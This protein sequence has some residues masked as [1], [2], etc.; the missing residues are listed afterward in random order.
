MN[1]WYS[2]KNIDE[3]DSP[4][5]VIYPERVKQNITLA[6]QMIGDAN[7]LRPHV[8]TNKIAEVCKLMMDAGITKFKCA[9]IAEAEMLAQ[10]DA[11]DILL[12]YQPVGPK[13]ERL[14][15]LVK[16]Y[17]NTTFSC[18]IDNEETA[19][20]LS[21]ICERNGVL[22]PIFIDV[23]TGMNRTGIVPQKVM[24]LLQTI[25]GYKGIQIAG[26]QAY[27]GH[28]RD[29]DLVVR[30]AKSDEAFKSI[31]LLWQQASTL[32]QHSLQIV[33]GGTPTFPTHV[34]RAHV[35]CSPGT[36]VF[37]DWG[38]KHALPDEPF[39]YAALLISR[40]IS[41]IDEQTICTD[42]GHK[43]VAAE[44][45]LPRVHFLN[46]PGAVPTAQ[47]EEHL[48]LQVPAG[49]QYKPGDVLYGV[50]VHICPTVAL[51]DTAYVIEN[52]SMVDSWKVISR[53]RSI[54]I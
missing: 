47:S 49:N 18:L 1:E 8:K 35:E 41:I 45:P 21:N 54:N 32:L 26:L 38:Y 46:A 11:K 13:I 23:N 17:P 43:S 30:Q 28:I 36:F 48:V 40:V 14:I 6:L 4:A 25:K 24:N 42:L 2:I 27:D 20:Q 16:A 34:H 15:K 22:L 3:I 52:S 31:E 10:I 7:K 44:N 29:S 51:Y 33:M 53:N 19:L 12:A 9:T 50:P 37:W 5:L 39:E